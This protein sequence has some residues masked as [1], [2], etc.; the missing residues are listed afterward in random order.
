M[1]CPDPT[2][3]GAPY[4]T[5]TVAKHCMTLP[6]GWWLVFAKDCR[7]PPEIPSVESAHGSHNSYQA[8]ASNDSAG[9]LE[10]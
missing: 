4:T 3:G 7:L 10:F 5:V 9:D 2:E 1:P 8:G 6:I